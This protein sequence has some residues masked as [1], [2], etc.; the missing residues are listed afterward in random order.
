MDISFE[1]SD[2]VAVA[3][4][5]GRLDD[6]NARTF[7][8]A[9]IGMLRSDDRGLILDFSEITFIGSAGL[10]GVLH[11]V[12]QLDKTGGKALLCGLNEQVRD[13]FRVS[14]FDKIVAIAEDRETARTAIP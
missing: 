9:L 7:Q 10:R 3:G 13:V 5:E 8:E 6:G 14:G 2:G 12:R 4:I 11:L 1:R